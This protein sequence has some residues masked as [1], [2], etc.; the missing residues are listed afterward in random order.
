MTNQL[1]EEIVDEYLTDDRWR[2]VFLL[3][4]G[5]MR[6]R[7]SQLLQKMAEHAKDYLET[8][9]LQELVKWADSLTT[10]SIGNYKPATKRAVAIFAFLCLSVF[11]TG[12]FLSIGESVNFAMYLDLPP[13]L[14]LLEL[15]IKFPVSYEFL[16]EIEKLKIFSTLKFP[17]LIRKLEQRSETTLTPTIR[18]E[19]FNT[20]DLHPSI[21]D[22]SMEE[23]ETLKKYINANLL[24]VKC[25]EA[26]IGLSGKT[27]QSIED[28][29]LKI[30]NDF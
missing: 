26:S 11:H 16:R 21:A 23:D 25:K 15:P 5:L 8:D 10:N 22:L 27:W 17:T 13:N 1:E 7:V 18:N 24:I 12:S 4:A 6:S 9:K 19:I 28:N 20:F 14:R 30:D 3:V 29:L 2:E